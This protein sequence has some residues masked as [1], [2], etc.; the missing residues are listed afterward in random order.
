MMGRMNKSINSLSIRKVLRVEQEEHGLKKL[1]TM[2]QA[3]V[4]E[5][6][7]HNLKG[8]P[9]SANMLKAETLEHGGVAR[10][11]ATSVYLAE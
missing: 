5:M 3:K 9:S 8:I 1:P 4:N 11:K 7:E 10:K 2:Q 6:K